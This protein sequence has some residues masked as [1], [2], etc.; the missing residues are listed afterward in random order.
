MI[1][2]LMTV[3]DAINFIDVRTMADKE[4]LSKFTEPVYKGN[5]FVIQIPFL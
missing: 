4:L 3:F 2:G 5:A 1:T